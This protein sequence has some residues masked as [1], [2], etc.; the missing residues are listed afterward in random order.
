LTLRDNVKE[1]SLSILLIAMALIGLFILP[2]SMLTSLAPPASIKYSLSVSPTYVQEGLNT[3]ITASIEEANASATYTFQVNVTAPNSVPY[4]SNLTITTNATGSGSNLT[5]FA[6]DFSNAN[7]N[8]VGTY[9]VTLLNLTGN[10]TLAAANFTVGLTD[11]LKYLR[12]ETVGIQG[13]GYGVNETVWVDLKF[14]NVSASGFPRSVNASVEGVVT[15]SWVIPANASLGVYTLTLLNATTTSK[16][17]QD[18]QSFTVEGLCEVQTKNLAGKPLAEVTV[19]VYN[20]TPPGSFLN[21]NKKTNQTGGTSFVLEAG[22][23]TFKA[24]WKDVEVGAL[25]TNFTENV[26]LPLELKLSNLKLMVTDEIGVPIPLIELNLEYNYTTRANK[27][28][29]EAGSFNTNINGTVQLQNVFTNI[30]YLIEAR[31][32]GSLFNI[33]SISSLPTEAWNNITIVAPTYTIQIQIFD[34]Q[35]DYAKELKVAAYEWSSGMGGEPLQSQLTDSNRNVTFSLTFGKYRLRLYKDAT[36]LNEV[37]LNL[38][39]NQSFVF[40]CEVYNVDL[41]VLVID[42]FGQPIPNVSVEFQRKNDSVYEKVQTKTTES[43][44]VASFQGIIG[45]DSRVFVSVAG[46]ASEA[47]YLY[48]IGPTKDIVFKLDGYVAVVGY[49]LETSQFATLV[50]SFILIAAFTTALN[51]KRLSSILQRRR[52]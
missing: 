4:S 34:S 6:S 9:N 7:T 36:F 41:N 29:P 32:Y 50:L 8:F 42:Y 35:D 51:Y 15:D 11:K 18:V 27:T 31:R 33:T 44:G 22:N 16:P 38:I 37:T 23:Y 21:L 52:K 48:L 5:E 13:S 12:S 3:N 10:E 30:S 20:A 24:F 19:E 39:E 46:R 43:N 25:N 40:N 49:A 45:G 47:Q 26:V 2:Q 17:V 28:V 1:A 14:D